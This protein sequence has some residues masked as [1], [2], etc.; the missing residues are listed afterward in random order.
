MY[1]IFKY[2]NFM[3]HNSI[4]VLQWKLSYSSLLFLFLETVPQWDISE[5]IS[6]WPKNY[7][8]F[9][10]EKGFVSLKLY[11]Y[12]AIVNERRCIFLCQPGLVRTVG[13]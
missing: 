3:Q 7:S 11:Y 6:Y 9:L 2:R 4:L 5:A 13:R 8:F 1:V 10:E 12:V